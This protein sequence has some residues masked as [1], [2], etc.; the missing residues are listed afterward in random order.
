MMSLLKRYEDKI[1][2]VLGCFDRVVLYGTL[3]GLC[4][5]E[6]MTQFL[7]A[8]NIRIFDYPRWAEPLRDMIRE[9]AERIAKENGLQIEH[10]RKSKGFRKEARVAEVLASR[11][12]A[13]GLVHIF[14]AMEECATYRPWHDK[15]TGKTFLKADRSKC[16]HYYF[17][18]ID[19]EFGLCYVRV[20][21]WAPFRLQVYF[22]GHDWLAAKLRKRGIPFTLRDNAFVA[23]DD[24]A[25][26]QRLGDDFNISQLHRALD[27]F[28]KQYCPAL[29]TID[30]TYHWSIMQ[31]EYSTDVVFRRQSDLAPIY[32]TLTRTAIHAVKPDHVATFLGRKLDDRYRDELG[33]DFSTRIEGTRIR[34]HMGPASIKMYDKFSLV[35]RIETTANDVT[36]FKHHR[37]VEQR[38]GTCA[39]KMAPLKKTIYSL[40]P[41]L[42]EMLAAANRRYLEFISALDDPS[43][44]IKAL[45][46]ISRPSTDANGRRHRGFNLFLG[47]DQKLFEAILRGE[48]CISGCRSKDIKSAMPG[49]TSSQV[50]GFLKR[51]RTHGLLKR[52]GHTYKYYL[53]SF[54][55][56]VAIV[57]LKIKELVLIPALAHAST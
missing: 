27:R 33:N 37:K 51:M 8:H 22:N 38:D 4:Y 56:H 44:G 9:N 24:F 14:S 41:D 47:D 57:A 6:G 20:P 34:H 15:K 3:P 5:A 32:E 48:F 1:A 31:V 26:A 23:I 49:K 10:V 17:Y 53:T 29:K 13:P 21:T 39:F 40:V 42:R 18:F 45:D 25:E 36:F 7:Y 12:D 16:L 43:A 55:R 28:A 54:G 46:T 30:V 35:L 52:V 2:G 19:E 50:A 11:G